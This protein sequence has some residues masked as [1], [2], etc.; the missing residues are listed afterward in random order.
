MRLSAVVLLTWALFGLA[1]PSHGVAI[2]R[3]EQEAFHLSGQ[4]EHFAGETQAFGRQTFE[5]DKVL[6]IHIATIQEAAQ[7]SELVETYLLDPWTPIQ[8]GST[9]VRVPA[10]VLDNVISTLSFP[11]TV[12]VEN[13][14]ELID[15]V[16]ISTEDG[17][18]AADD[19]ES[20]FFEKY[21]PYD[22][23]QSFMKNLV[24]KYPNIARPIVVGKTFEGRDIQG[25]EIGP[26]NN[27]SD[28]TRWQR[29]VKNRKHRQHSWFADT[30]EEATSSVDNILMSIQQNISVSSSK[31]SK[32][33]KLEEVSDKEVDQESPDKES[34]IIDEFDLVAAAMNSFDDLS[35]D[36]A[37]F[38]RELSGNLDKKSEDASVSK[39]KRHR[40]LIRGL[41]LHG[42]QHAREWISV[43]VVTYIMDQLTSQYGKDK[44]IT[45]LVDNFQWTLIPVLNVDGYI[46]TW[47]RNRMWRKNRQPST[48]PFCVGTDPNRNWAYKWNKGGSSVNPCSEAYMGTE[49]FSAPEPKAMADYIAAKENVI[50]YIDFHAFAQLWMTPFG[51]DCEEFPSDHEDI[52][53][54]AIGAAKALQ[55]VNGKKFATGPVCSTIY[56][57]SGGSLDWTYAVG[58]VKYSYAVEL[59]DTGNYGFILPPEEILPS[60]KETLQA[61]LQLARFIHHREKK[62]G[63][64]AAIFVLLLLH[65]L[66]LNGDGTSRRTN[67]DGALGRFLIQEQM[68]SKTLVDYV[69]PMIGTAGEGHV[70][71]GPTLPH[72]IAKVGFDIPHSQSG[73]KPDGK[74]FGISHMHSSGTGGSNSYQTISVMPILG[75]VNIDTRNMPTSSFSNVSAQVGQFGVVLSDWGVQIEYTATARGAVH[76]YQIQPEAFAKLAPSDRYL[77]VLFDLRHVGDRDNYYGGEIAIEPSNRVTGRG[78]YK[79]SWSGGLG[80]ASAPHARFDVYFCAGLNVGV[81]NHSIWTDDAVSNDTMQVTRSWGELGV[82]LKVPLNTS[83]DIIEARVGLSLVSKEKACMNL[84]KEVLHATFDEVADSNRRQWTKAL[85]SFHVSGGIGSVN[86]RNSSRSVSTTLGLDHDQKTIFYSSLYRTMIMPVNKTGENGRHTTED[87]YWNDFYCLW[88]TFRTC[89]CFPKEQSEIIRSFIHFGET[90]GWL[91][92]GRIAGWNG[93]TQAGSNAETMIADAFVKQLPGIDWEAAYNVLVKDAEISPP[94]F[95]YHGRGE[96]SKWKQ[97]GYIPVDYSAR[98]VYHRS[99]AR[100]VEYAYNDFSVAMVAKGL[101]KEIEYGKYIARSG[102]WANLWNK[103]TESLGTSGFVIPKDDSGNFAT[104]TWADPTVCSPINFQRDKCFYWIDEFYEASSWTY[105][106]YTPQNMEKLIKLSGGKQDF[107]RRLDT[108]FEEGLYDAG[109]EP[110]FLIP[111][112]YNYIGRPDRTAMRTRQIID[113]W[114]N[115]TANGIPGN[116]DAAGQDVYLIGSP[117]WK[118]AS[119]RLDQDDEKKVFEIKAHNLSPENMFVSR[120][121]LNGP[122]LTANWFKHTD[123]MHGGTL[124]LWMTHVAGDWGD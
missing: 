35:A 7:L 59:R 120:A 101:S 10:H 80:L 49:P 116:D 91:P 84:E 29:H 11:Y 63:W 75:Q 17:L 16:P 68:R 76:R 88:D 77:N 3:Q 33:D 105:S 123:I 89:K 6:D 124:E 19:S 92:D 5:G 8:V 70:F 50:G 60:G 66:W 71:P 58:N 48:F 117:Q 87:A 73:Y 114:F 38:V 53:E 32:Q 115:S 46:Y 25:V 108:F 118:Y 41:V 40:H 69:D 64:R 57:A 110:S 24:K 104:G 45:K 100:T 44:E 95:L 55:N 37:N 109:N 99:G 42:G 106:F 56:P 72:A 122:E 96:L 93:I 113:K 51:A 107:L 54:A 82:V 43:A 90:D 26:S 9:R 67:S 13:V 30:V 119:I 79:D 20:A 12:S 121:R 78:Q 94:E 39:N 31:H 65:F 97:Y 74:V 81:A 34:S 15:S 14:Q 28:P 86:E 18:R 52:L 27:K 112:L 61:V 111:Y 4:L 62:D 23:I 36:F 102:N 98:P 83:D 85:S 47:E 2:G 1:A 22:E 103:E 21:H